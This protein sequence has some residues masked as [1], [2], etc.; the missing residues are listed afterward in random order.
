VIKATPN[1][2]VVVGRLL[3][4]SRS[5]EA[6]RAAKTELPC[7]CCL[8]SCYY[9]ETY[10]V[11]YWCL[12]CGLHFGGAALR[13]QCFGF[14]IVFGLSSSH[15][16]DLRLNQLVGTS[17]SPKQSKFHQH[18][19]TDS[20]KPTKMSIEQYSHPYHIYSGCQYVFG[21][22]QMPPLGRKVHVY[23]VLHIP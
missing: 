3:I 10:R 9:V 19:N 12:H 2:I 16:S 1:G 13:H 23:D 18:I 22:I 5:V 17:W 4:Y 11:D 21:G 6:A 7:M 15:T 14:I 20:P 8:L